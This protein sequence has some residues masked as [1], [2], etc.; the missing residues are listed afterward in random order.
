MK[1]SELQNAWEQAYSMENMAGHEAEGRTVE[2]IGSRPVG[3]RIYDLYRDDC[4]DYWYLVRI[5]LATGELVSETNAIF[6]H[7]IKRGRKRVM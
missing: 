4:G 5:L 7:E 1:Q 6:G 3:R 2:Y